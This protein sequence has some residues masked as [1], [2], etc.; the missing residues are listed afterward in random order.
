M[1][2]RSRKNEITE[3][4]AVIWPETI[5]FDQLPHPTWLEQVRPLVKLT[6]NSALWSQ[7][8]TTPRLQSSSWQRYEKQRAVAACVISTVWLK[9]SMNASKILS[10]V[11]TRGGARET[12]PA[13]CGAFVRAIARRSSPVMRRSGVS[14]SATTNW[15]PCEPTRR[16]SP[17]VQL[18]ARH[19]LAARAHGVVCAADAHRHVLY[20]LS[21]P[22]RSAPQSTRSRA[23]CALYLWGVAAHPAPSARPT[24]QPAPPPAASYCC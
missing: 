23:C 10:T 19:S 14:C 21:P 15:E 1:N 20:A 18:G 7:H 8:A 6:M 2:S 9:S 3:R 22:P 17:S 5:V 11:G 24:R 13:N 4:Y 12:K 16:R